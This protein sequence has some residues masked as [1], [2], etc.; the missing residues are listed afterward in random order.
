MNKDYMVDSVDPIQNIYVIFQKG[1]KFKVG[2]SILKSEVYED[3][4][5]NVQGYDEDDLDYKYDIEML[6]SISTE[7]LLELSSIYDYKTVVIIDYS[8]N[9][10]RYY[11]NKPVSNKT[12]GK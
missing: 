12:I 8:C 10:C 9:I 11:D 6:D 5:K 7:S 3:Y 2:D 4:V 1:G